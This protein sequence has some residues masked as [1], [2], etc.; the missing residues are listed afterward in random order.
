MLAALGVE[1]ARVNVVD[2]GAL[3]FVIAG[4]RRGR[5]QARRRCGD[6]E[7][8][9]PEQSHCRAAAKDRLRRSRLYLPGNEPKYFVN[10]G[11]HAPD[12]VILD[13]EDSRP[14]RREGRGAPAGPQR[15]SAVDFARCRAH[16]AHQ[17]AGRSDLTDLEEIIPQ[18]PDLILIPKVET[19]DAGCGSRRA[20]RAR[21]LGQHGITRP[22][23]LMPILESALGIENAFEIAT[24]SDRSRAPSPSASRTTPPT[25]AW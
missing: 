13:L 1:H 2:E 16:G 18:S 3:P 12:A 14:P 8:S 7:S 11:L 15:S 21:S 22:I 9:L 25:S 4:S 5:R 23:W 20:H 10:A 17:P 6:G 24:A 19:A